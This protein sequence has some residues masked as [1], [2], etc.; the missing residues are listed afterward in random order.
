[1]TTHSIITVTATLRTAQAAN[2]RTQ[3][4]ARHE[5]TK[6]ALHTLALSALYDVDKGEYLDAAHNAYEARD[7]IEDIDSTAAAAITR[8]LRLA[9]CDS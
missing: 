2:D 5:V 9:G 3:D 4:G 6:R 7:A 8:L 1:M